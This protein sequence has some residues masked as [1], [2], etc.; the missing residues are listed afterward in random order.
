MRLFDG[1]GCGGYDGWV[2]VVCD[3]VLCVVYFC[4][5]GVGFVCFWVG[6]GSLV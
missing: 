4:F 2:F 3:G 1:S 5:V 6:G